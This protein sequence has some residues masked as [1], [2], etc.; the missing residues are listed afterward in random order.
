MLQVKYEQELQDKE[1]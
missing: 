1:S